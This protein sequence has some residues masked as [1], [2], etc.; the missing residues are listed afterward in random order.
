MSEVCLGASTRRTIVLGG[1]GGSRQGQLVA[2]PEISP[3][4]PCGTP[5]RKTG[6]RDA[7][8]AMGPCLLLYPQQPTFAL[9]AQGVCVFLERG[10]EQTLSL[11]GALPVYRFG[12]PSYKPPGSKAE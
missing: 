8:L 11:L 1:R 12:S 4:S 6:Q 9:G 7:N 3:H 10:A 2:R 5:P